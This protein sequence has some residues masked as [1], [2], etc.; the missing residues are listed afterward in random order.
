MSTAHRP[1]LTLALVLL[2]S[3]ALPVNGAPADK[4]AAIPQF[5]FAVYAW[6]KV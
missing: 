3:G 1:K 6:S 5:G 4:S 2:A